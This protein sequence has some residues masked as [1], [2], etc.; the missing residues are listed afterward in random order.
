[1]PTFSGVHVLAVSMPTFTGVVLP[2]NSKWQPE[3]GN[4]FCFACTAHA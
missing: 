1:M 3:T 2:G 4:D